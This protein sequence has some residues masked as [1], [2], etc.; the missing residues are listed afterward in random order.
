MDIHTLLL[1]Q[2]KTHHNS[3]RGQAY[4]LA[5]IFLKKE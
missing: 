3:Q 1:Q 4:G 5:S 2:F